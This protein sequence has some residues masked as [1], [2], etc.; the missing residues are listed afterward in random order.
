MC[1]AYVPREVVATNYQVTSFPAALECHLA[2]HVLYLMFRF[3]VAGHITTFDGFV[4]R[5]YVI[6]L[7]PQTKMWKKKDERDLLSFERDHI[8][9]V[10]ITVETV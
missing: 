10:L 4:A 1:F 7:L 2:L 3:E 6:W 5:L 8:Q 9:S